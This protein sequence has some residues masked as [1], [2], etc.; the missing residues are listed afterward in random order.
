MASTQIEHSLGGSKAAAISNMIVRALS[1]YTGRGPTKAR[2]YLN[3][4]VVTVVLQDTLTKGERSLVG[5]DLKE[6]VLTMRKAYQGTMRHDLVNGVEAILGRKVAAFFS[7][8]HVDPDMAVEVFVLA[9]AATAPHTD[10][11]DAAAKKT[12][13]EMIAST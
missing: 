2:T 12:P 10:G 7:D 8:N 13:R 5:D 9:P 4:D 11:A 3:D 1:E 6:L